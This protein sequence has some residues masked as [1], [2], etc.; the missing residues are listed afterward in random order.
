MMFEPQSQPRVYHL[1]IGVDFAQSIVTG[2]EERLSGAGPMDWARTTVIVNT[3]RM[4]KRVLAL[5]DEG[6]ARLLPRVRLLT[7]IAL[8]AEAKRI[9][10]P[11]SKIK[12]RLELAKL[13][14]R[15][16]E[17]SPDLAPRSSVFDLAD[18]LAKLMDEA[19]SEDVDPARIAD[20]DVSEY[21]AHWE[22]S[23][24]FLGIVQAYL[25][26]EA[27]PDADFRQSQIID[28]LIHD[29]SEH[30][31]TE[32]IILAG[33]TGSRGTTSKL[34]KAV[35]RL[36]QGAVVL[37]GFDPDLSSDNW[38][39]LE[40]ES[41]P[42]EDHPQYRLKAYCDS[43]DIEP[44]QL[45]PWSHDTPRDPDRHALI[46]LSLRPAPITDQWMIEGP[47][48]GNLVEATKGISL[49]EAP[50]PRMESVA[51]ALRIRQAIEDGQS[52]ALIAPDRAIARKVTAALDQWRIMPDD[53]AGTLLSLTMTGR[54]LGQVA[55]LIGAKLTSETLLALLKNPLVMQAADRGNHL[56]WTRDLELRI[57]KKGLP[58][59]TGQDLLDWAA[60]S[61][62]HGVDEWAAHIARA[63]DALAAIGQA[64]L[65]EVVAAH[66]R[67]AVFLIGGDPQAGE[68]VLWG[69][70]AGQKA[71]Q[72]VALLEADAPYGGD[73]LA[74]D[75][76]ALWRQVMGGEEVRGKE[77][78]RSD[79]MI[80]G[81]LEARI[82]GTDLVILAGLNEGVW[83]S[84][85]APDP[86]LN[87]KMRAELG[88][89]SPDRKIG[90]S[91]HDYQIAMGAPEV[92]VSRSV[93][94][95]EAETVPSR[96]LNRLTNLIGGLAQNEGE[97]AL[98]NMRTR[99]RVWV[100]RAITMETPETIVAPANRPAPRPPFAA[101]PRKLSVTR[102]KTL[103]RNPYEIYAREIL[104]LRPLD[105]LRQTPDAPLRGVLMHSVMERF[106][107]EDANGGET[108]RE[109]LMR[110]AHEEIADNA[111]WPATQRIWIARFER[112][113]D[114]FLEQEAERRLRA[115]PDPA[116]VEL[117]GELYLSDVD[118]TLTA[119]ADRIDLTPE[120]RAVLYDYKTGAPPTVN[121]QEFFD[122]QLFLQI[123]MLEKG[124]F[125]GIGKLKVE[126]AEFLGLGSEAPIVPAPLDAEWAETVEPDFKDLIRAY[127]DEGLGYVA[128]RSM[129]K[130]SHESAYDLLSR[131]G[132]WDT[133]E[134]AVPEDLT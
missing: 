108:S 129:E 116:R 18:S 12:R 19:H 28:A 123:M 38:A 6:P 76:R 50:S 25:A 32:P 115:H 125:K 31:P 124:A 26:Q 126:A 112:I 99:G 41:G 104:R 23:K 37:P 96:W 74:M 95:S 110:L 68:R 17:V 22:R 20:L 114:L 81:T 85:P 43:L 53:S 98:E 87:R 27:Q 10:P 65:E 4:Q 80:W 33:S 35:A 52:V 122:R 128:R 88:L 107:R 45:R 83:P 102:F 57:R 34:M 105:P 30:S 101:R 60:R 79:V 70:N 97:A 94:S 117:E 21:S 109:F 63:L 3:A 133:S 86:W 40:T 39:A 13:I 92:V 7:D 1:P 75:Y 15:L 62:D 132:E 118:F 72:T 51:V 8:T 16:L 89:L 24:S 9:P 71:R 82:G 29:W 121:Q 11:V 93:K 77:Q 120:G 66:I 42:V 2:L 67:W 36:P 113:V 14:E 103:V 46:S 90:L 44:T 78:T 69:G 49:I 119:K 55:E 127:D 131:Y 48:L 111:P 5:F 134:R 59:P 100:D 64:P 54:F 47:K 106:I 73:F 61:K 84:A 58:F 91:A 130:D 56:R